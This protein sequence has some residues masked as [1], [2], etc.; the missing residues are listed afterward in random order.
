MADMS[1][2]GL[3]S[4]DAETSLQG[5][6]FPLP[7]GDML[8]D[9]DFDF[10][11]TDFLDA[12]LGL[13]DPARETILDQQYGAVAALATQVGCILASACKENTA[14]LKPPCT[15]PAAWP[16][17]LACY[18]RRALFAH[19]RRCVSSEGYVELTI[20]HAGHALSFIPMQG[21]ELY[22]SLVAAPVGRIP[23]YSVYPPVVD[24][25]RHQGECMPPCTTLQLLLRDTN[26]Y[27]ADFLA[28]VTFIPL[29]RRLPG[30]PA[31][32]GFFAQVLKL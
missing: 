13:Q 6:V 29:G 27:T 18:Y 16:S 25:E 20:Y 8:L 14:G 19:C 28:N 4:G 17:A 12:A 10:E 21:N 3:F 11:S 9:L 32:A 5:N 23:S 26:A 24:G 1:T 30:K 15:L 22:A 2:N 7:E 31:H